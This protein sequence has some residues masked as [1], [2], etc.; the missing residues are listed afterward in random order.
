MTANSCHGRKISYPLTVYQCG[1]CSCA[2]NK[3]VINY[4]LAVKCGR[5][6]NS[7][8]ITPRKG[9]PIKMK[10]H[11]IAYLGAGRWAVYP[12]PGMGG[13]AHY[14]ASEAEAKQFLYSLS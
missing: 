5:P 7:A 1:P 4:R 12:L 2:Q 13:V 14:F 8:V 11:Y 9:Q 3:A 6:G 10:T